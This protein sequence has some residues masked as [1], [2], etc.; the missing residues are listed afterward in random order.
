MKSKQGKKDNIELWG[1][2]WAQVR[3]L[4]EG[5]QSRTFIVKDNLNPTNPPACLKALKRKSSKSLSRLKEEA[6]TLEMMKS[7]RFVPDLLAVDTEADTPFLVMEFVE[8]STLDVLIEQK[9]FGLRDACNLTFGLLHA[10][11]ECHEKGIVHRDLKPANII[12]KPESTFPVILDFGVGFC[13][14]KS[15]KDLT[16]VQERFGNMFLSAPETLPGSKNQ[17]NPIQDLT[18]ICGILLYALTGEN[19]GQLLNEE[20]QLPHQRANAVSALE[21]IQYP[22]KENLLAIFDK[23][24]DHDI[25]RRFQ[26][27]AELKEALNKVIIDFGKR[28]LIRFGPRILSRSFCGCISF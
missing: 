8:G 13:S 18:G 9:N 14:T 2:R 17:R 15:R 23:G 27:A 22:Q 25:S 1:N 16:S 20:K 19:I 4:A 21:K 3:K 24:F 26:S 7:S 12:V 6:S 11:E 28:N 5:G 10:I